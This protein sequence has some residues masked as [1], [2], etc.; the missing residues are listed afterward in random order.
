MKIIPGY[1]Q[2]IDDQLTL[3][4]TTGGRKNIE[5]LSRILDLNITVHGENNRQYTKDL[6]LEHPR[7]EEILWIYIETNETG[8]IVS[9]LILCP[10]KWRIGDIAASICEMGFVGT[11]EAYRRR[12]FIVKLNEIFEKAMA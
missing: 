5:V 8:L 1:S 3:R 11:L 2:K 10:L 4:V 7:R 6:F 9:G 12:G